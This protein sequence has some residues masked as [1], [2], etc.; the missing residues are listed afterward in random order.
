MVGGQLFY[1][2]GRNKSMLGGGKL[3][4][5]ELICQRSV[6]NGALNWVLCEIRKLCCVGNCGHQSSIQ[7]VIDMKEC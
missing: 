2:V 5:K 1:V 6:G 3:L 7:W 4:G